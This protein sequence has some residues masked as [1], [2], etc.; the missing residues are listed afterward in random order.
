MLDTPKAPPAASTKKL[1]AAAPRQPAKVNPLLLNPAARVN[2][3]PAVAEPE[4]PEEPAAPKV[5]VKQQPRPPAAIK[6]APAPPAA[7]VA[8]PEPVAPPK[9]APKPAGGFSFFGGAPKPAPKKP[10]EEAVAPAP[11][12]KSKRESDLSYM[13]ALGH[14]SVPS[15][16]PP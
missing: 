13:C 1:F 11:A 4:E 7:V 6:K 5:V 9:S 10:Q 16:E 2:K 12:P 14:T 8:A 15:S 3:K